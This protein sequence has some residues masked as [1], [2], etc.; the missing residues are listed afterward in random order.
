MPRL[1]M[2]SAFMGTFHTHPLAPQNESGERLLGCEDKLQDAA[3]VVF[4]V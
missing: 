2:C 4:S 3:N 1:G